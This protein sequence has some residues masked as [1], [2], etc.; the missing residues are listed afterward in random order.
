MVA[1]SAGRAEK[2]RVLFRVNVNMF[3]VNMF[4]PSVNVALY[5]CCIK[6]AFARVKAFSWVAFRTETK[7]ENTL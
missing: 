7:L 6:I 1:K 5:Q 2:K 4:R 3:A